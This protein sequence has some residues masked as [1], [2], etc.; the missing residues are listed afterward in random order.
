[1]VS[2]ITTLPHPTKWKVYIEHLAECIIVDK[3]PWTCL[4]L[5]FINIFRILWKMINY[6]RLISIIDLF[7]DLIEI[8]V[9]ENGEN[10]AKNLLLHHGWCFSG[11]PYNYR[12]NV[13][14]TWI[15]F[16]S[17]NNLT[18]MIIFNKFSNSLDMKII[19]NFCIISLISKILT[20]AIK[21]LSFLNQHFLKFSFNW[22]MN[23]DVI[24]SYASLPRIEIFSKENSHYCTLNLGCLVDDGWTLPT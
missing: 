21:L 6:Q 17:I 11:F 10:W 3:C 8:S 5:N 4:M 12:S 20:I 22:G 19:D 9:S 1:M 16:P 14:F 23:I 7:Y 24:N 13:S 15:D 18:H 2:S